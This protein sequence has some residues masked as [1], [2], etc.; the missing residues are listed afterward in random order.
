VL[1]A[2]DAHQAL[3]STADWPTSG[4]DDYPRERIERDI[5]DG[6]AFGMLHPRRIDPA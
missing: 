5:A 6:L 3:E 1:T 2:R 4:P